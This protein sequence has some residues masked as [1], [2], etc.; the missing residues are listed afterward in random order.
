[1]RTTKLTSWFGAKEAD[2]PQAGVWR[3]RIGYY[4]P[5]TQ[6]QAFRVGYSYWHPGIR[7]WGEQCESPE[8][9]HKNRNKTDGLTRRWRGLKVQP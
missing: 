7:S 4:D 3:T 9:A 5:A 6:K 8:E 1:M 2:P